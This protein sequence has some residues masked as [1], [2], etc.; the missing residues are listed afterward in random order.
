MRKNRTSSGFTLIELLVV[1]A[2][3][4]ILAGLLLP[5]LAKAKSKAH[6][7]Y[8]MNNTNQMIKSFHL[9]AT[10]EEDYIPPNHDDGNSI[11]WKNWCS[12]QAS[13]PRKW[14]M[15]GPSPN[16]I[17]QNNLK[18]KPWSL[19]RIAPYLAGNITV[20]RCPADP[21][22]FT[23]RENGKSKRVPRYR[24]IAMSQAVGTYPHDS[25]KSK[26]AVHGPWLDGNH[27]HQRGRRWW[28]YGKMS[29]FNDPGAAGTYMLVDENHQ[30]INDAGFA[31]LGPGAPN[32]RMI[33]WPATYHNM[34]AGF[35]F[36]DGHSE[37]RKWKWPGTDLAIRGPAIKGGVRSP[38]IEWMQMRTSA[39]IQK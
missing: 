3:I 7:I 25:N 11:P 12:G 20:W 31:T 22:M 28:T 27:G 2:I 35:A 21:S 32:F 8:C 18:M 29:D 26:L 16:D 30:S 4:A 14:L 5:A 36:A 1:I 6:G 13:D 9:Y 37:I 23:V 34:A 15:T 24:S 38:D 19:N 33:D 10:D 17:A 39:L